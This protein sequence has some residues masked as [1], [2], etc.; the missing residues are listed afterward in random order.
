MNKYQRPILIL[1]KKT[2]NNKEYYMGSARAMGVD[3]FNKLCKDTGLC[4]ADGHDNAH[5]VKL[6]VSDLEEFDNKIKGSLESIE[7]KQPIV[8]VDI[9][10]ELCDINNDLIN[11][12]KELNKISGNGF[13]PI[14]VLLNNIGD[15]SISDM[16]KGKHLVIKPNNYFNI[17]K[18][19][20]QGSFDEMEEN[21]ILGETLSFVGV[22][23]SGF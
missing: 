19:N 16:S 22:L 17:I 11:K 7:F 1:K 5:G 4:E 12:L 13:K 20:F 18:W 21:A 15:Y 10:L 6:L 3:S 23:D 2:I 14:N 8:E 9:V